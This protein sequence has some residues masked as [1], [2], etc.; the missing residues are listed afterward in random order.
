MP[1]SLPAC[2]PSPST[3]WQRLAW[4]SLFTALNA[5]AAILIA[6]GNTPLGD[7]PGG[8]LGLAYLSVALPGH[9]LALG[10]VVSLLP[11]L[12]GLGLRAPRGLLVSAVVLQTL[13]LCLLLVDAKV[14]ALYRFHLNAMVL[15]MVFGGVYC[16][17]VSGQSDTGRGVCL[18]TT[19]NR[20]FAASSRSVSGA[21]PCRRL[22]VLI[23][24]A[25]C[26]SSCLIAAGR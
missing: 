17:C 12:L 8:G 24:A 11:L 3:R 5:G 7:N 2:T 10:A 6:L 15:N 18:L 23:T 1:S 16:G 21:R 13:W 22:S 26:I 19:A 20:S 9:F 4:L 25:W 14:F